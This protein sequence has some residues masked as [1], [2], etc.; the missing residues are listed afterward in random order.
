MTKTAFRYLCAALFLLLA[1]CKHDGSWDI[2]L[3]PDN[4]ID[5]IVHGRLFHMVD[6]DD[7]E[8]SMLRLNAAE[9]IS[10]TYSESDLYGFERVDID[11]VPHIA[12]KRK[13]E[14]HTATE[15]VTLS[16]TPDDDAD[17]RRNVLVI[18][19]KEMAREVNEDETEEQTADPEY[20]FLG[21]G[22]RL[23]DTIGNT[24]RRVLDLSQLSS[25]DDCIVSTEEHDAVCELEIWSYHN[26]EGVLRILSQSFG[27][28]FQ[29]TDYPLGIGS[30]LNRNEAYEYTV[31]RFTVT[32]GKTLM[33]LQ[34]NKHEDVC[35]MISPEFVDDI[36]A[37][38]LDSDAFYDKWG[39]HLICGGTMGGQR[40]YIYGRKEN[41]YRNHISA[42]AYLHADGMWRNL[43][44]QYAE[45]YDNFGDAERY[46]YVDADYFEAS[47]AVAA[48]LTTGGNVSEADVEKWIE[49][50]EEHPEIIDYELY[51]ASEFEPMG[52]SFLRMLSLYRDFL[53]EGMSPDDIAAL[54]QL[55]KNYETLADNLKSYMARHSSRM[56]VKRPM[57]LADIMMKRSR[58]LNPGPF[59]AQCPYNPAL[60]LI[61]FP[62]LSNAY[63]IEDN[64]YAFDSASYNNHET[65]SPEREF[66]YYALAATDDCDGITEI[67]FTTEDSADAEGL[68]R[69]GDEGQES[70]RCVWI[71]PFDTMT[72][73]PDTRIT[74]AGIADHNIK[75]DRIITST[76][77]SELHPMADEE[78]VTL[79]DLF[80]S[81]CLKDSTAWSDGDGCTHPH[82]LHPVW[83]IK[84]L[85]VEHLSDQTVS[86]PRRH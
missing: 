45:S 33:T 74:A 60:R 85:T 14:Q 1:A 72:D 52:F 42:D 24:T 78:M 37:P 2:A 84:P 4:T 19:R 26:Y 9:R 48:E 43:H 36:Q 67:R 71:K 65:A 83:S 58:E 12:A 77:G 17:R 27:T 15:I 54:G 86:H 5:D 64:G 73:D 25:D 21:H 41:A 13:A 66:W 11:G 30:R 46:A 39:T 28:M 76:G 22:T 59:V 32:T 16:V 50:I 63:A 10:F 70:G 56:E 68:I 51:G 18:F 47:H 53:E 6:A 49:S 81:D 3:T 55:T 57:V 44:D 29:G 34:D 8:N 62:M 38:D 79:W 20:E 61:Y 7:L 82:L 75:I 40:I 69:R 31:N 23:Y 80:W 35:A